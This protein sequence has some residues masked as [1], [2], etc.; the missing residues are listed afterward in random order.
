MGYIKY[1]LILTASFLIL[2]IPISD[3]PLFLYAYDIFAPATKKLFTYIRNEGTQKL[4]EGKRVGAELIQKIPEKIKK[5][6]IPKSEE[7]LSIEE[8]EMLEQVL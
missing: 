6:E 3:R 4:D 8:R 1:F 2:C 5:V 7:P